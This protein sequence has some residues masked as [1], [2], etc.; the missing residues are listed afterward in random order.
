MAK[1]ADQSLDF[2]DAC[3]LHLANRDRIDTLFSID[4]RHFGL[5]RN[6]TGS[7]LKLIPE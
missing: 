2:A 7:T 5:L 4:R 3:L 6:R 1:Y